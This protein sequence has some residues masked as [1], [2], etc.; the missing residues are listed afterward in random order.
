MSTITLEPHTSEHDAAAA[1]TQASPAL[2]GLALQKDGLDLLVAEL[3]ADGKRTADRVDPVASGW[4][5]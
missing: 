4:G 3:I 5:A 1:V 2:R